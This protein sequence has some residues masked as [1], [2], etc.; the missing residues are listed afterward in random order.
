MA[1][2]LKDIAKVTGASVATISLVLNDKPCRVS[3]EMR[4][5]IHKAA[6]EL[7]YQ[8][9]RNAV[10][11]ITK[12]SKKIG[13]I[14]YDIENTFFAELAKGVET[15]AAKMGYG[16]LLVNAQNYGEN[17][18]D[19]SSLLGYSD[20][21]ALIAAMNITHGNVENYIEN[22]KE[23]KK[24]IVFVGDYEDKSDCG[25]VIFNNQKGGYLA[26]KH[27]LDLGHTKI[28]CITGPEDSPKGRINGYIEAIK[29][30]GIDYDPKLVKTGNYTF[31]SGYQMSQELI[32]LGVSA[33]FAC[34][35]LMAY[36]VFR[37]AEEQGI[38]I[39]EQLSVVGFD[40]LLYSALM[41]VPLTS[42]R[43]P[44]FA[45]GEAACLKAQEMIEEELLQSED[46]FFEPELVI[47]KSC[48]SLS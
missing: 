6:K 47:R 19:F 1:V 7:N 24:P 17:N 23:T 39:P 34:N 4:E 8:P 42:V 25:Y 35:D 11:L 10:A 48:Q 41:A 45:M 27:L 28:G 36:G 5:A 44:A 38:K 37:M 14:V 26:T 31:H 12:R 32:K 9:N 40:D 29:D 20:I 21:D 2:R 13:M 22:F 30:A 46:V 15:R 16:L 33:I 43:Q 18:Q 3:V